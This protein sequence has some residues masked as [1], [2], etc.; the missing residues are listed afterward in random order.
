M[1]RSCT[2]LVRLA[3]ELLRLLVGWWRVD[4]IRA[5]SGGGRDSMAGPS[6]EVYD[7]SY[8]SRRC[9]PSGHRRAGSPAE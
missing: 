4:R 5:G 3:Q 2:S 9:G 8:D 1:P 7:G 6:Q